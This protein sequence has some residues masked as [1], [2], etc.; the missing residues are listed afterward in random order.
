MVATASVRG[1]VPVGLEARLV[2]RSC[3]LAAPPWLPAPPWLYS[4]PRDTNWRAPGGCWGGLRRW[5]STRDRRLTAR[6]ACWEAT[7]L[8]SSQRLQRTKAKVP[9]G[10]MDSCCPSVSP[11]E[12]LLSSTQKRA[13]V[14]AR[15]SSSAQARPAGAPAPIVDSTSG[16]HGPAPPSPPGAHAADSMAGAPTDG[17]NGQDCMPGGVCYVYARAG[18]RVPLAGRI[19]AFW[20]FFELLSRARG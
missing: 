13:A 14:V 10:H 20:G 7:S 9:S 11:M 15:D 16:S 5:K 8:S 4:R 17:D 3:R 18:A 12:P 19:E 2:Y 1:V 6:R